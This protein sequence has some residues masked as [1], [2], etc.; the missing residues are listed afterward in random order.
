MSYNFV[1]DS[2]HAKKL[3]SRLSSSEVGFFTAIGR[4]AFFGDHFRLIGK[5]VVDF[6]L[7]LI[8]LFSLN[9]MAEALR[10]NIGSKSAISLQLGPVDP[11]FSGRRG[12]PTPT[13]FSEK[14]KIN[15]L[16]CDIKIRPDFSSVLSQFTRLTDRQTDTF[17]A[18]Q[19]SA[20]KIPCRLAAMKLLRGILTVSTS[21]E[22]KEVNF[23]G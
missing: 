17:L 20:V 11:N 9:V 16:S 7:V 15:G 22:C 10:T 21:G 5:R 12:C 3:W 2:F 6:L 14:T 8:E 19:C 13:I 4:F 23:F 18:I 1:A